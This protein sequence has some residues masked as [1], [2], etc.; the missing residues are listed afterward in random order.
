MDLTVRL[1]KKEQSSSG[2]KNDL[3]H[4]FPIPYSVSLILCSKSRHHEPRF[5]ELFEQNW[6]KN[7]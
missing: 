7:A 4:F 1:R 3:Q 6:I 2:D 5:S